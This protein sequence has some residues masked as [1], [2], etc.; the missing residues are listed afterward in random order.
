MKHFSSIA[1]FYIFPVI[2]AN[3]ITD[4]HKKKDKKGKKANTGQLP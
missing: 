4:A 3:K 2:R 1:S